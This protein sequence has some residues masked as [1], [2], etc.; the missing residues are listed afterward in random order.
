MVNETEFNHPDSFIV[1]IDVLRIN[2]KKLRVRPS[3]KI[4]D[5]FENLCDKLGIKENFMFGICEEVN[6]EYNAP[7]C[8]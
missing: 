5:V 8:K 6:D 3:F 7:L 4:K 2:K 1:T